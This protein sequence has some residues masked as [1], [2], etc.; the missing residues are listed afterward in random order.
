[1]NAVI[2]PQS[3]L[4]CPEP[5]QAVSAVPSLDRTTATPKYLRS[6]LARAQLTQKV[7]ADYLGVDARTVRN[8]LSGD[9]EIPYPSQF[10]LETLA[11]ANEQEGVSDKLVDDLVSEDEALLRELAK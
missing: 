4:A 3:G 9:T 8:Y 1:M 6:L 7:A 11:I 10:L 2:C 5:D